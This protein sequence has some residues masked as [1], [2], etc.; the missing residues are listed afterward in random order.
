MDAK[1]LVNL[2]SWVVGVHIAMLPFAFVGFYRYG[3]R[4]EL[5]SK[6]VGSMDEMLAG[7]RRG[8]R[9]SLEQSLAPV[10]SGGGTEPTVIVNPNPTYSERAQNPL[11]TEAFREALGKFLEGESD[12]LAHYRE[13]LRA[14]TSWCSWAKHTTWVVIA[15][16]VWEVFCAAGFGLV[17]KLGGVVVPSWCML[18]SFAPSSALVAL[19]FVCHIA[20]TIQHNRIHEH[21]SRYHSI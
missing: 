4:T 20:M 14:R 15:F 3:D 18:G 9:A 5:F 7:M 21:K 19:F 16:A 8:I 10:F 12:F 6:S 1:D 2:S 13:V 17:V 11:G